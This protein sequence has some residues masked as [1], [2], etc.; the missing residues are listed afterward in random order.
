MIKFFKWLWQ[1]IRGPKYF[2]CPKF[3]E[4]KMKYTIDKNG[5][6]TMTITYENPKDSE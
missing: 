6:C 5:W 1:K 2:T 3:K 4:S